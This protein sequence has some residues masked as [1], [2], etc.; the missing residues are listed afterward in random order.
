MPNIIKA[1]EVILLTGD[2]HSDFNVGGLFVALVDFDLVIVR[3]K[4]TNKHVQVEGVQ[5]PYLTEPRTE[6]PDYLLN[7]KLVE[8]QVHRHLDSPSDI[9]HDVEEKA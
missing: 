1:G 9:Y 3:R 2:V 5:F 4:F 6:F 8:P 7:E